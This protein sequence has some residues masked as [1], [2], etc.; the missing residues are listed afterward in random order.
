MFDE[1]IDE[2]IKNIPKRE[3]PHNLDIVVEGGAFN[4]SYVLGILFFLKRANSFFLLT[5]IPFNT[6]ANRMIKAP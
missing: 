6:T 2:L 5:R 4:G 1:Y 3:I